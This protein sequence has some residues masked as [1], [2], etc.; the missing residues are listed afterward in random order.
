MFSLRHILHQSFSPHGLTISGSLHLFSRLCLPHR[1][2]AHISS[3]LIFS[4]L[5]IPITRLNMLIHVL[6]SNINSAFLSDQVSL[7]YIITCLMVV[8]NTAV[9]SLIGTLLSHTIPDMYRHF[10]HP[11]PTRFRFGSCRGC[12]VWCS[13]RWRSVRHRWYSSFPRRTVETSR[14]VSR[15]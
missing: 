10:P 2:L 3:F 12:Q 4:I 7:P 15:R 14:R 6:S 1:S 11:A 8:L 5:R 13:V 9:S